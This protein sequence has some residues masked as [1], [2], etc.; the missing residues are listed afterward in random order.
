MAQTPDIV[1]DFQRVSADLV[2]QAS[3]YQPAILADGGS[4]PR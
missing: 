1:R 4:A 2:R 3:Q